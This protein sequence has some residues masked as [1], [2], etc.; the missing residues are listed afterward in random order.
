MLNQLSEV[1]TRYCEVRPSVDAAEARTRELE[2]ELEAVK[3]ELDKKKALIKEQEEKDKQMYLKVH[4]NEQETARTEK[5]DQVTIKH[6]FS[7]SLLFL[8][9]SL[10]VCFC[11]Y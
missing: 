6:L 9:V 4:A 10:C 2:V 11:M 5:T 8:S 1:N 7:L 3:N